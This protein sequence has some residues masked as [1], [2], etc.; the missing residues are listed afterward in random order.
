MNIKELEA[1]IKLLDDKD[2]FVVDQVEGKLREYY[3]QLPSSVWSSFYKELPPTS[4]ERLYNVLAR[5]NYEKSI[6]L[7]KTWLENPLML[8]EALF[9]V[10]RVLNPFLEYHQ[11]LSLILRFTRYFPKDFSKNYSALEQAR[12]TS[13]IFYKIEGFEWYHT[14]PFVKYLNPE[15]VVKHGRGSHITWALI[16]IAVLQYFKINWL[17]LSNVALTHSYIVIPADVKKTLYFFIDPRTGEILHTT[18]LSQ[19]DIEALLQT[20][21]KHYNLLNIKSLVLAFLLDNVLPREMDDIWQIFN[22][23]NTMIANSDKNFK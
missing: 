17:L 19:A 1:L 2:Q 13:H 4:K 10:A 3:A 21:F 9:I 5:F 18:P 11:F 16:I 15:Y 14:Q 20:N 6:D 22:R 23:F 8:S 7:M 12:Y